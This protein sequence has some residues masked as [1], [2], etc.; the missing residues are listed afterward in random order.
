VIHR[1]HPIFFLACFQITSS[2]AWNATGHRL[3]A[4]MAYPHMTIHAQQMFHRYNDAVNKVYRPAS[5]INAAIWLDQVRHQEIA[6]FSAL[7]YVNVPF[8]DDGSPLPVPQ[9]INAI[10]A[11]EKSMRIL[12]NKY[13]TDFDKGV[14]LRIILH[15][16]G[17]L[18]QPLHAATKV[19]ATHPHGDQ[20]GQLVPIYKSAIANNLHAYWDSGGGLLTSKEHQHDQ[21]VLAHLV[22]VWPCQTNMVDIHPENWAKESHDLAV[23]VAYKK[24]PKNHIPDPAYQRWAQNISEQ[25]LAS[26]GCRLATLLNQMS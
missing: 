16:V 5:F 23:N 24:L 15:V 20:G 17:D 10:W 11:I 7:H 21:E 13:A 3:I 25:Q 9:E 1:W 6:W 19:S 4:E 8:T 22:L 2:F 26:A 14:A 18:H 12:S